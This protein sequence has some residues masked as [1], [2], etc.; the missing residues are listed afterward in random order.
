M[1]YKLLCLSFLARLSNINLVR[2][3]EMVIEFVKEHL[4]GQSPFLECS[5]AFL[6]VCKVFLANTPSVKCYSHSLNTV[7]LIEKNTAT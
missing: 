1:S 7:I 3:N 6:V 2:M 4:S 5:S